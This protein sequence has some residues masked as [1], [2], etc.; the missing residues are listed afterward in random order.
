MP[1]TR[2]I[3][4]NGSSTAGEQFGVIGA[5]VT[6]RTTSQPV[7]TLEPGSLFCIC[8]YSD[9][10]LF[11]K[12]QALYKIQPSDGGTQSSVELGAD[13]DSKEL[14]RA[15]S[16]SSHQVCLLM[17]E[18]QLTPTVKGGC[19]TLSMAQNSSISKYSVANEHPES[20]KIMANASN[21]SHGGATTGTN[22]VM[23]KQFVSRSQRDEKNIASNHRQL[24]LSGNSL[25]ATAALDN[26]GA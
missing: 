8:P 22:Q 19:A 6:K 14:V 23:T 10:I 15:F 9:S 25:K 16:A 26:S 2:R 18:K 1:S 11:T 4:D 13:I 21:G 7:H 5:T 20:A 17:K 12:S 3:V 24:D